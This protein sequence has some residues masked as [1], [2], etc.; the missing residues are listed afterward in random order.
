VKPQTRAVLALLEIRGEVGIT[1]MDAL[2]SEDI[3]SLRL[4]SRI[5]ELRQAGHEIVTHRKR[6]A[7]GAVPARYVLIPPAQRSLW[8]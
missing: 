2:G 6:T 8:P 5:H 3:H 7:S 1:P 4:A